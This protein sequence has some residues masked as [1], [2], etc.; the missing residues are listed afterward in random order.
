MV[1]PHLR[2][3]KKHNTSQITAGLDIKESQ[4]KCQRTDAQLP[5]RSTESSTEKENN[6]NDSNGK[7]EEAKSNGK[8]EAN[9]ENDKGP[10]SSE[11]AEDSKEQALRQ[12]T[13]DSQLCL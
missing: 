12:W 10:I 2:P 5:A 9:S 13:V 4:L 8:E 7:E 6:E 11:A 3:L 1:R